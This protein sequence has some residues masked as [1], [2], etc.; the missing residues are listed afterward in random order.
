LKRQR[1][2]EDPNLTPN[3]LLFGAIDFAD[4]ADVYAT[5]RPGFKG[6][7][8]L[9]TFVLALALELALKA[10]LRKDGATELTLKNRVG[11]DVGAAY[12]AVMTAHSPPRLAL[13]PSRARVLNLLRRYYTEKYLEYT[14]LGAY[15]VPKPYVLRG[16]V[17]EAIRFGL[18]HVLGAGASRRGRDAQGVR[19]GA[20]KA[21]YGNASQ[22]EMRKR[23]RLLFDRLA[24]DG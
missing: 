21:A 20:P 10:V 12:Q 13:N 4:L 17:H 9:L 18:D 24:S 3:R 6:N 8:L 1:P 16:M 7:A 2:Q 5:E 15:E 11:H 23:Q 14:P 22:R 19:M